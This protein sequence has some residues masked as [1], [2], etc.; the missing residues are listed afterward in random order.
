MQQSARCRP[1][2]G[3]CLGGAALA[4]FLGLGGCAG[5]AGLPDA[6]GQDAGRASSEDGRVVLTRV[7]EAGGLSA[8]PVMP[9][10][11]GLPGT[12]MPP[13]VELRSAMAISAHGADAVVFDQASRRLLWLDLGSGGAQ[14]LSDRLPQVGGLYLSMD[15]TVY[16]TDLAGRR[17]LRLDG[18][19]N[20]LESFGAS[21]DPA[22]APVDVVMG[23]GPGSIGAVDL[24]HGYL[25]FFTQAGSIARVV[26]IPVSV[27]MTLPRP[28][29]F[30]AAGGVHYL[31]DT[32]Q[33]ELVLFD[34]QGMLLYTVELEQA[35]RPV[36][37]AVDECRRAFVADA[38]QAKM[39]VVSPDGYVEEAALHGRQAYDFQDVSDIWIDGNAL[40]L[41]N[42]MVGVSGW[43]IEPVCH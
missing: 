29:L 32:E 14:L 31:L 40:Y 41:A 38:A 25:V 16:V 17:V 9:A 7:L 18:W 20:V 21:G 37:V 22:F 28:G 19:G 3:P 15:R 24:L 8:T 42:G 10:M 34:G 6:A 30:A 35:R 27:A 26:E 36:A 12:G 13:R 33:R 43:R 2:I 11:P 23:E 5:V 1:A 4:A 39:F